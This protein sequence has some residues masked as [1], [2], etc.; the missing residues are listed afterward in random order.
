MPFYEYDCDGADLFYF[1]EKLQKAGITPD[2]FDVFRYEGL[3]WSELN[4][5]TNNVIWMHKRYMA[6]RSK[7]NETDK[8]SA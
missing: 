8:I 2:M 1:E 4:E 5:I 7:E 3:A 6:E